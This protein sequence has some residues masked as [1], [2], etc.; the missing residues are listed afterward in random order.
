MGTDDGSILFTGILATLGGLVVI[1][2]ALRGR[3][4]ALSLGHWLGM[5]TAASVSSEEAWN[6]MQRA[7]APYAIVGGAGLLVAGLACLLVRSPA[8]S[9]YAL[10]AGC[11]W[12]V[13]WFFVGVRVGGRAVAAMQATATPPRRRKG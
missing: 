4:G 12:L 1:G 5:R 9:G 10:I 2:A 3:A 11:V 6:A 7:G 13:A 8:A